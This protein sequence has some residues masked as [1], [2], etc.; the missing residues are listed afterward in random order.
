M[1]LHRWQELFERITPSSD[2]RQYAELI[3]L[4]GGEPTLHPDFPEI[5][6]SIDTFGV[7]HVTFTN[8]RWPEVD[9]VIATFQQCR[10]FMGLLVSLHG[11]TPETHGAFVGG[12]QQA[13]AETC[14]N[15]QRAAEAGLEVF[16]NTVLTRASCEQIEKIIRL[17]GELGAGCAV[18]NRYLGKSHPI[19]PSEDQLR[20]AILLIER[21]HGEGHSCHIG[22]CVPQCFVRNTSLGANGGIE[23]C[24]IAP[25]GDV[26]PENL[27]SY[28]FG[29]LFEQSIEEIWQSERAR[30]YREQIPAPC[31]ECVELPRCRGGCRSVTVEYGLD[32]DRLMKTPLREPISDTLELDPAWIPQPYFTV[33]GEPFGY[34]LCRVN[35]SIPV[36]HAAGPLL[37][38]L[39]GAHTFAD[40]HAR[41]GDAG[42]ALLGQLYRD[43]F[44]GVAP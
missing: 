25:N 15:I 9:A 7:A 34:L 33:R 40:L 38:A 42:L 6:K 10:H 44:L 24:A 22:D 17:S 29:N 14:R 12:D 11:S 3:R 41:F 43:G 27:T 4:T 32:G 28:T 31:L 13:F 26:R 19:E 20:R 39:D 30:W 2:R 18:F 16:T 21:L 5:V 8:G 36:T 23:H 1:T 37:D 35:W